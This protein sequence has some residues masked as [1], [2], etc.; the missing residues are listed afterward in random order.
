MYVTAKWVVTGLTPGETLKYY[1]AAK[2]DSTSGSPLLRWG[3]N[4]SNEYPPA[5]M[6]VTALPSNADIET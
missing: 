4:T 5:I 2:S 1:L 3:S 6:K